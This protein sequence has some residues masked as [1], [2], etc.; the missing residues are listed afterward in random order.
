MGSDASTYTKVG[1]PNDVTQM[2]QYTDTF[3]NM[4]FGGGGVADYTR[5]ALAGA[6]SGIPEAES[7]ISNLITEITSAPGYNPQSGINAFLGLTPQLQGIARSTVSPYGLT[8]DE[9]ATQQANESMSQAAQQYA[10]MGAINSGA[11][12]S[13]ISR[14]AAV[15]RAQLTADLARTQ[16][17][18]ATSL[19]GQA[20]QTIPNQYAQAYQFRQNQQRLGLTGYSDLINA[21]LGQAGIYGNL[22]GNMYGAGAGLAAPQYYTPAYQQ[23]ED[24][25]WDWGGAFGGAASGA[26]AGAYAGSLLGPETL[27]LSVPIGAGIGGLLGLLGGGL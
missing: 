2:N 18:A 21:S 12:L 7:G 19:I 11:A 26:A 5:S 17:N 1:D 20:L 22:L 16:S 24:S 10:N 25:G 9:L 8:A 4:L 3:W 14:G 13:A 15:P 27:G 6:L 23:Q